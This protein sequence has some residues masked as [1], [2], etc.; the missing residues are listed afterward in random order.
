MDADR[1]PSAESLG[2]ELLRA[3]VA[4]TSAANVALELGYSRTAISLL[5]NGKYPSD[6]ARIARK[7]FDFYDNRRH[8]PHLQV[9]ITGRECRGYATQPFSVGNPART[10]HL[11]ACWRCKYRPEGK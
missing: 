3:Q 8:C 1:S 10:R 6:G 5:L 7:A 4:K 2:M 11:Q 9:E